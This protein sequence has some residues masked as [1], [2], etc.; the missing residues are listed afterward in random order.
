M[1]KQVIGFA[2]CTLLLALC[3]PAEAQQGTKIPR[4]GFLTSGAGAALRSLEQRLEELGYIKGKNL[5]IE[6][7]SA[8]GKL[9]R[10]PD[11]AAELVAVNVRLIV[12]T[13]TP[14]A[15]AENMRPRRSQ[16]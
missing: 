8:E 1:R 2:L 3:S 5:L 7:R 15:H 12:A 4:I 16:L 9:N 13:A 14:A 11:L 10:L 6:Y